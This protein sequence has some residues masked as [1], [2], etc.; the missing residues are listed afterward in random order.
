MNRLSRAEVEAFEQMLI[1]KAMAGEVTDEDVA[2]LE[3]AQKDLASI[4][5]NRDHRTDLGGDSTE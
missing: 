5:T 4:V 3:Q 1:R 2:R